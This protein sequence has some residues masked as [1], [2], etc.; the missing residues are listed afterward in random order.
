MAFYA[1]SCFSNITLNGTNI[2]CLSQNK[3]AYKLVKGYSRGSY[4]FHYC[5][6]ELSLNLLVTA[7]DDCS[8]EFEHPS[9][10]QKATLYVQMISEY[11]LR[12]IIYI[13]KAAISN[14]MDNPDFEDFEKAI[15]YSR[16]NGIGCFKWWTQNSKTPVYNVTNSGHQDNFRAN[17]NDIKLL[18]KTGYI[19]KGDLLRL[20]VIPQLNIQY[21]QGGEKIYHMQFLMKGNIVRFNSVSQAAPVPIIFDNEEDPLAFLN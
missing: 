2:C 3:N 11:E 14:Q 20:H 12:K 6:K 21:L 17:G 15:I 16:R 7:A 9:K 18:D 4:K 8:F 10:G 1:E 13:V 19:N 5:G